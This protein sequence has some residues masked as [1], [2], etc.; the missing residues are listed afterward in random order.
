MKPGLGSGTVSWHF[1][2]YVPTLFDDG[3]ECNLNSQYGPLN[4][5]PFFENVLDKQLY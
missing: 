3:A 5:R 4:I 1:A 2:V